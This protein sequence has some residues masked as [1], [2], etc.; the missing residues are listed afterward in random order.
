M[1]DWA[2]IKAE[3]IR[4][5]STS[6]RKLCQ[7]YGVSMSTLRKRAK[8]ENWVSMREQKCHRRDTRVVETCATKEADEA[9]KLYEAADEATEVIRRM[10][11]EHADELSPA[12]L[13]SLTG[14]MKD[15]AAVKGL[16]TEAE[17]REQE[18]RI[19]KLRKEATVEEQKDREIVFRIEGMT[20]EEIK[21]VIG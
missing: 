2:K 12:D 15:I 6:Y 17:K 16:Q 1:A 5:E 20:D 21:G 7:K 13:R 11:K 18:A 10:L 4:D 8:S 14:A 19:A 9:M 3:Y